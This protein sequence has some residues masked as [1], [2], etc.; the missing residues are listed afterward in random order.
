M[1]Q[2]VSYLS[3]CK[4]PGLHVID[5]TQVVHPQ[6]HIWISFKMF[7]ISFIVV[8]LYSLHQ[9]NQSLNLCLSLLI[10][11]ETWWI[12]QVTGCASWHYTVTQKH[13]AV[14]ETPVSLL[15]ATRSWWLVHICLECS[16]WTPLLGFS[17]LPLITAAS[18]KT[19]TIFL[20]IQVTS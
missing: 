14:H 9:N 6:H 20:P 8:L 19:L 5:Y 12:L 4:L 10:R 7:L 13:Q 15:S 11:V 2:L 16:E 1:F 17:V 3:K 18:T